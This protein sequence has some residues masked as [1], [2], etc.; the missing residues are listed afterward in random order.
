M[1]LCTS[2]GRSM[3]RRISFYPS[4]SLVFT[5]LMSCVLCHSETRSKSDTQ[6]QLEE[7]LKACAGYCERLAEAS[8]RFICRERIVEEFYHYQPGEY[9]RHEPLRF[10]KEKSTFVYELRFRLEEK[11]IQESRILVEENGEK[12]YEESVSL[13][14]EH[15]GKEI[16]FLEPVSLL[17][18]DCQSYYR[19]KILGR[20][21]FNGEIAVVIGVIPSDEEAD[22]FT[23]KIWV[24][25][26]DFSL[27]KIERV[28]KGLGDFEGFK[29]TSDGIPLEPHITCVTEFL[30]E[31]DGIRFPTRHSIKEVYDAIFSKRKRLVRSLIRSET[32]V[33]YENY[34]VE[35][36]GD[37]KPFIP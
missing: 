7:I 2:F 15:Y 11:G 6:S 5:I 32:T 24:R 18:G 4:I 35:T 25:D 29:R 36:T 21:R 23:A 12:K 34:K 20:E 8:L 13:N 28:Q 10:D 26:G 1:R 9:F 37:K 27:L 33:V 19:Y 3:K 14:T 16:I 31:K 17:S 30:Y 22:D